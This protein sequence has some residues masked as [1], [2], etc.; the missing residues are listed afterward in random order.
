MN[1]IVVGMD[2]KTTPIEVRER[3]AVPE[4][5]I[6]EALRMLQAESEIEEALVLSTCNRVE[7]ILNV[8][9]GSDGIEALRRFVRSYYNLKY[10]DF[11]SCFYVLRDS[12]A[13]RHLARVASGLESMIVGEPQ[14]LGQVKKAYTLAK[15]TGTL[16]S[17]LES[18]LHKVFSVAKRV[19]TETHVAEASVSVSSA[20]VELAEQVFGDL[21]GKTVM[22][23][24]AGHMG[25][26][27]ARHLV[28]KGAAMVLVS[29]RTYA[30]AVALAKELQG[31]AIRFD[32]I[33]E[34]MKRA[35]IVISSTGCPHYIITRAGMESL[36]SARGG[37][38]LFLVDIAV[39]RDIDPSVGELPGCRLAN[40]DSLKEVTRRNLRQREEAR[41]SAERIIEEEM[42]AF[43]ER[44]EA[45][46]VVPTIVS[47]RRRVEAIRRSEL[48][49]ARDLFGNL[50]PQQEEAVE[51]VT[52]SLVNKVLHTPFSELKRAAS[53]PD[54]SEIFGVVRSVFGLEEE[55][56]KTVVAVS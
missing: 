28:S 36:I 14:V 32:R 37:R 45:L 42:V 16:G 17:G 10:D 53:R 44:Q 13:V 48:E 26:L 22:I 41:E 20:A 11:S 50:T 9:E 35:D 19:R 27:A 52:Q 51:V 25:E 5:S 34:A 39:P 31:L 33:W 12:Q 40:I 1:L 29:N 47:L 6:P 23:I 49:R 24:G 38:P 54:R 15:E 30:Q 2:H 46:R 43:Q 56:A 18:A 7:F 55:P 21:Q 8:R 4:R 3:F